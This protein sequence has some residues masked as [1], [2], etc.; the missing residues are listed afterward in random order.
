M[1]A[2]T[3]VGAGVGAV[4]RGD[5]RDCILVS[6]VEG[7]HALRGLMGVGVKAGGVGGETSFV[8]TSF[9]FS[10]RVQLELKEVGLDGSFSSK[11]P[12]AGLYLCSLSPF[13]DPE[14]VE[15]FFLG[16]ESV[17][18]DPEIGVFGLTG[19]VGSFFVVGCNAARK[20]SISPPTT[21]EM[22]ADPLGVLTQF[23]GFGAMTGLTGTIGLTGSTAGWTETLVGDLIGGLG[24]GGMGTGTGMPLRW[25]EGAATG[26]A[27]VGPLG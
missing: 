23:A 13:C 4:M 6:P 24:V 18:S 1:G 8:P 21:G 9:A 19:V 3:G 26:D 5:W 7:N 16:V 27:T 25:A 17:D 11:F 22:V 15:S 2:T 10:T 12:V 14:E 20:G